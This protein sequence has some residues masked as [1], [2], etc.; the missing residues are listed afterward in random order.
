MDQRMRFMR[1][2]TGLVRMVV[3]ATATLAILLV[4]FS[5]YQYSQL[6]PEL[7]KPNARS[8][9][10]LGT[11]ADA[12]EAPEP[13]GSPGVRVRDTLIGDGREV[14]LS[15]YRPEGTE[16]FGEIAFHKWEPVE[17]SP[18]ELLVLSPEIR[19]RTKD[20]H[21]IRVTGERAALE[22]NYGHGLNVRRGRLSGEVLI[23][24]DRLTDKEREALPPEQRKELDP[25]Q[26]VQIKLDTL[27]FDL[28]YSKVSAPTGGVHL[29][30][31]DVD[32]RAGDME[33]RFNEDEGRVEYLRIARGGRLEMRDLS[34]Q[35]G[36]SLPTAGVKPQQR[37]TLVEWL[38]T[39]VQ[40]ALDAQQTA[41]PIQ[42]ATP[43]TTQKM[44][45]EDGTPVFTPGDGQ[46]DRPSRPQRYF[47][48][49]EKD[50]EAEQWV[51]QQARSRLQADALDIL[52]TLSNEDRDRVRSTSQAPATEDQPETSAPQERVLLEWSGRLT[53]EAVEQDDQ[54][55]AE[56]LEGRIIATGSPVRISNPEGNATCA[57]LKLDPQDSTVW[58]T[59]AEADPVIVRSTGQGTITGMEAYTQRD[60]DKLFIRVTGPGTLTRGSD[61]AFAET[62]STGTLQ[63]QEQ[64]LIVDFADRLEVHG[65]F[66]TRRRIDFTGRISSQEYRLLDNAHFLGGVAMQQG[67]TSLD[68]DTLDLVFESEGPRH[69]GQQTIRS[70]V[71]R[72]N[73][74]MKQGDDRLNASEIELALTTDR[75]GKVVPLTAIAT[76]DVE[77]VQDQR[78]IRAADKLIVDFEMVSRPAPPFDAVKAHAR[79]VEAGVDVA[80]VDWEARR[81]EHESK[82]KREAGVKRLQA[83]GEVSVADP[84]QSL[85]LNAHEL[86]C[87]VTNGREIDKA[88]VKGTQT[89]PASVHL[90]TL[91][92]AGQEID[93]N[94]PD[95]WA[96]VPGAGRLSFRSQK[97]L[98]GRKVDTPVPISIEWQDWMK[99]QG[100][101]NRAVFA[102]KVHAYSRNTTEFD[103]KQLLVEFDDSAD[104]SGGESR[105]QDWW[106][107]QEMVDS[108][109]QG[110]SKRDSRVAGGFSKEPA[111]MLATGNAVA[112]TSETDP[113][114]GALKSRARLAGP[115][116]SVNL[117]HDVSKMLI[118]GGGTLLLEDF[119]PADQSA[120][121]DTY[122]ERGLFDIE[123]GSG[124]SKTLIKWQEFMWYD[125]SI[126][127]TRFE[128]GVVLKHFSGIG[129]QR[130]LGE[131]SGSAAVAGPGRSTFLS[132]DVL[133]A[134][135]L[136]RE[137]RSYRSRSRRM[138]RLSA[139]QLGQFQASGSVE[140]RDETEGLTVSAGRVVYERGRDL[141]A[142]YGTPQRRAQIVVQKPG[143]LPKHVQTE[144]MFYD[145]KQ[146]TIEAKGTGVTGR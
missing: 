57:E 72:G 58:M 68:A 87:T 12:A 119:R 89:H 80:H 97:D 46:R 28:E 144:R 124:P 34:G 90:D 13:E 134:D 29:T 16:A 74:A 139:A 141:L 146:G 131:I 67:A 98:D 26:I 122:A 113:S 127:Q 128:G 45:T 37:A 61:T 137:E 3:V 21:G 136:S 5:I 10:Q 19:L 48:R 77:A 41:E 69:D 111:Y 82:L 6:D 108:V 25:A 130:A 38:R 18:D 96:H 22:G 85:D 99:Y 118:E 76:T 9:R 52:R 143:E 140:I 145:L 7:H 43:T 49:F 102:G 138:G 132:C 115:Q 56:D 60:E 125:F 110:G 104:A 109:G 71:A 4:C 112:L 92:V 66:A 101:E 36:M 55:W 23:E 14:S 2:G 59:G 79:A 142:I 121:A 64:P 94:V 50:I 81:A 17:G 133:T 91:T 135:F 15:L 78:T 32:F 30:A 114:S 51:G 42:A 65:H 20:G 54:R 8:P 84:A 73:V 129:L 88:L 117:R 40:A 39:T 27:D 120:Q 1:L 116:L 11:S 83:F 106:I 44:E 95:Q 33:I 31:R 75:H 126:D 103:C 123:E 62:G 63:D 35:L 107:F 24:Y 100:R 93:L 70:V 47:A 86:D 105:Q 53:V